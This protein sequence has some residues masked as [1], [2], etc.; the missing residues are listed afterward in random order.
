MG[1]VTPPPAE[2]DAS[3]VLHLATAGG[4]V[5]VRIPGPVD[6]DASTQLQA[7]LGRLP[8]SVPVV[9]DVGDRPRPEPAELGH[10][11]SLAR[12]ASFSGRRVGIS[13]AEADLRSRLAAIGVDRFASVGATC[14]ECAAQ[15][16]SEADRATAAS[17]AE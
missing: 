2:E 10:L 5:Q 1:R 4:I 9:I 14:E 17:D 12:T 11:L 13:A 3:T 6:D 7:L 15:L 16:T 8:E